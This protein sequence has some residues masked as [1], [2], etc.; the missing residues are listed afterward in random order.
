MGVGLLSSIVVA[1][2]LLSGCKSKCLPGTV[3]DG[4]VCRPAGSSKD[5]GAADS[6]QSTEAEGRGSKTQD[7]KTESAGAPRSDKE[8]SGA[9]AAPA[10]TAGASG[11]AG[12]SPANAA[13]SSGTAADTQTADSAASGGTSGAG[14]DANA[15]STAPRCGDNVVDGVELCD[16]DC[17]KDCASKDACVSAMLI[18]GAAT[19]DASC[20]LDP[21]TACAA[22]DGCCPT[23]CK[24]PEDSD[25]SPSCGDG[26]L[27][28]GET[29]E[30]GG[31]D[32]PCPTQN[33][34][35]DTDPC[36]DDKLMGSAEQCSAKCVSVPIRQA[37]AGDSCCP[38]GANANTD[39]D[40]DPK[41]GNR[42]VEQGELCDGDCPRSCAR[43]SGCE[44]EMLQGSATQCDAM[45][46]AVTITARKD[47]DGCC[48]SGANG[49]NDRDC[50]GCHTNADC[51]S[52]ERCN[53]G[54][55]QCTGKPSDTN[56]EHCGQCGNACDAKEICKAGT[57]LEEPCGN[58]VVDSGEDC[59][60]E[61]YTKAI[62][63]RYCDGTT[64]KFRN[65]FAGC[66][67]GSTG[68]LPTCTTTEDCPRPRGSEFSDCG[69]GHC[70]YYCGSA[71]NN[72]PCPPGG[73]CSPDFTC[74]A[75]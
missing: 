23:D 30:T 19:C 49:T 74:W 40:C 72:A 32:N 44:Q 60:P 73:Y 26:V 47:G 56:R 20:A 59:D 1:A 51:G 75:E 61:A 63:A 10:G 25:C 66:A 39:S 62:D 34:C 46:V 42:I 33:D 29:C 58:G 4:A 57:C 16:G 9:S 65:M 55:C 53:A 48:P 22:A 71:T 5:A 14:G 21:I 37:K 54:E 13:G 11:T 8:A 43:A 41:C 28:G 35:A 24:Y 45:C 70:V 36:T 64:C 7:Q 38:T 12:P 69:N 50:P 67:K 31:T 2:T 52:G 17:P 6:A 18:G 27:T 15:A 3:R 68:C